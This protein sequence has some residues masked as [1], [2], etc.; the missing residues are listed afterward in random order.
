MKTVALTITYNPAVLKAITVSQG[1]FMQQGGASTEFTP[2]IDLAAGRVDIT[3][4][5]TG[6][7]GASATTAALLAAVQF[8]PVAAGTSQISVTGV[9]TGATG[10]P[11]PVQ[12]VSANVVVR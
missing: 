4:A 5:R 12:M 8:Q 11:I 10:Q 9:L 1:S 7:G 3:I 2:R 6:D